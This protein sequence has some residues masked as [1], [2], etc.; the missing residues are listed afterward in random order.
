MQ[1]RVTRR[2]L[3]RPPTRILLQKRRQ[4]IKARREWQIT[5]DAIA[6][7]VLLV[8]AELRIL[9]CNRAVVALL[10]KD[11]PALIGHRYPDAV[12]DWPDCPAK[13]V[14]RNQSAAEASLAVGDRW[15]DIHADPLHG[16]E[17]DFRGGVVVIRDIT[18]RRAMELQHRSTELHLVQQE[19]LVAIGQLAAG[20]AHEINNPLGII[21]QAAQNIARRLSAELPANRA[22]AAELGLDLATLHDYLRQRQVSGLLDAIDHGAKR[23]SRIVETLL[24]FSQRGSDEFRAVELADVIDAALELAAHDYNLA[25]HYD[26]RAIAVVR[27]FAVGLPRVT[28]VPAEIEQVLLN[29]FANAAQAMADNPP[30]RPP[31]LTVRLH[32]EGDDAVVLEIAD[33]GCG[34]AEEV[35]RRV[36]EPFFTTREPGSGTGLGLYVAQLIVVRS[37]GGALA[38]TSTPGAGSTF[39]VRLPLTHDGAAQRRQTADDSGGTRS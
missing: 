31:T 19:K 16:E 22:I 8:D 27:E 28:I 14:I 18:E 7:G 3:T 20:V 1:P 37:H 4:V 17:G 11:F 9:R 38:V 36:F 21:S 13:E 29:L 32:R 2:T 23:A 34:M 30:H 10:G 12:G 24:R 6:D 35:S 25:E 5:F 39:T 15:W 26:F 33:N